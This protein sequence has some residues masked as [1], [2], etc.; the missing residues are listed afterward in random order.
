MQMKELEDKEP[1]EKF[2]IEIECYKS[3][4]EQLN[5]ANKEIERETSKLRAQLASTC[6]LNESNEEVLF[7]NTSIVQ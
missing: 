3:E 6:L 2:K 1:R 5:Q 7:V 4:V